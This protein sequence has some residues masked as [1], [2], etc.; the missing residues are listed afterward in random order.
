MQENWRY[1]LYATLGLLPS[2]FF[3]LRFLIQWISSEQKKKSYVDKTFWRLSFCGN[4]L[5]SIHYFIQIQYL[6]LIIQV[7]NGFIAWRNIDLLNKNKRQ[8]PFKLSLFVLGLIILVTSLLFFA[9]SIIL[10]LPIRMLEMPIALFKKGGSEISIL[11][12]V[13]GSAGCLLF[14]SRFWFQWLGAEKSKESTLSKNFWM[15][16]IFGSVTALI[17]FLHIKD[18]VSALNYSLG[19]IPYIRN[20]IL[21]K[22]NL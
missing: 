20:L 19:L 16:S 3:G 22:N 12:H 6:L 14:A 17:Y 1:F 10:S 11:W 4:L 21:S 9:Q 18:W 15:I 2:V 5:L 7:A 13:F 8:I